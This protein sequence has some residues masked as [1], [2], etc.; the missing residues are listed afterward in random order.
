M[1]TLLR[2][3]K[4]GFGGPNRDNLGQILWSYFGPVDCVDSNGAEVYAMFMGCHELCKLEG[5][6]AK[7]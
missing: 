7:I 5:H 3:S 1:E 4:G 6:N 2:R